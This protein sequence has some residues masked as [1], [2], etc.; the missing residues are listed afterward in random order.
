MLPWAKSSQNRRK[1]ETIEEYKAKRQR[2]KENG[3]TNF[4]K[5]PMLR[6]LLT[7]FSQNLSFE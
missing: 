3:K 2:E 6:N 1:I 5:L 7:Q 4:T